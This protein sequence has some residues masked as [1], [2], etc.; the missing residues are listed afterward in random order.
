MPYHPVGGH[1]YR[2]IVVKKEKGGDVPL[3]DVR[4]ALARG[5]ARKTDVRL[6]R[7]RDRVYDT[8]EAAILAGWPDAE[9]G[10]WIPANGDA[11]QGQ[12]GW[13]ALDYDSDK[14]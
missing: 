5:R 6:V 1:G 10:F 2:G 3:I 4:K 9:F 14:S 13:I 11:S 8:R 12:E 7:Q